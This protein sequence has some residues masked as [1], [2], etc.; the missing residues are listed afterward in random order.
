M[1]GNIC[2][3]LQFF[4]FHGTVIQAEEIDKV[5]RRRSVLHND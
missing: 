5:Q 3:I 2:Q 4:T 1:P